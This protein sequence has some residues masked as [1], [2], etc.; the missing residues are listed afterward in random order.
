M[1]AF[2]GY[3]NQIAQ[4]TERNFGEYSD[5]INWY[6]SYKSVYLED[7]RQE[8]FNAAGAI[9]EWKFANTKPYLNSLSKGCQLCGEGEWSCLFISGKCN[10][11]CFYCPAPQNEE[12]APQTQKLL[13]TDPKYY[14]DYINRFGFKGVSFSGGEPLLYFERTLEFLKQVKQNCNTVIYIWM[15]TNG[16]LASD[17]KLKALG[18]AGLDEIRFDIGAVNYNPKI[19]K[20]A[21]KY[22]ANVTVEIPA[23]PHEKEQLLKILPQLCE[24]GVTNINFHQL[25]LTKYNASKLLVHNYT[26]LHGEQPTVAESEITALEIM[27]FVA[28]EKLPLGVNYCNFQYK[29]RFQKAGYRRKMAEVLKIK[30][31]EITENGFCRTIEAIEKNESRFISLEQL[32]AIPLAFDKIRICYMGRVIENLTGNI[33]GRSLNLLGQSY[34]IDEGLAIEPIVLQGENIQFYLEMMQN[35]GNYILLQPQ[36]FNAWQHEFIETEMR[37]FY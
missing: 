20:N 18:E 10:A 26:I 33:E 25:R 16:I 21:A 28:H 7:R 29:N 9:T 31:E 17:E 1:K 32:A 30:N 6:H 15:Y 19:L 13:F 37:D 4:N 2:V 24:Y 27:Q 8:L 35:G 36:L 11:N 12:A 5:R 34:Q 14:V 3:L 23:V 22:I